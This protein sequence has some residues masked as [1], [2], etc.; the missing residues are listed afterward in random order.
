MSSLVV[1]WL[2]SSIGVAGLRLLTLEN[3]LLRCS[4]RP[5]LSAGPQ[6]N[7]W[8]QL[9]VLTNFKVKVTRILRSTIS[10]PV[11]L[12]V[13]PPSATRDQFFFNFALESS[14]HSCEF[15]APSLTRGR[16]CNLKL[17]L[18]ITSAVFLWY[19]SRGIHSQ[20]LLSQ[21]WDSP[22][23]EGQVHELFPPKTG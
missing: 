13:G 3:L 20:I 8:R 21:I 22:N 10:R 23:L 19:E 12:G 1:A 17:L 11:C 7:S 6:R 9:L 14:S 16:V 5:W 15:S 2:Q 4:S 18:G